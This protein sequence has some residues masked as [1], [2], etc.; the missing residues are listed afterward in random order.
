MNHIDLINGD[1]YDINSSLINSFTKENLGGYLKYIPLENRSVLA[2]NSSGDDI[3]NSI[4][5][6]AN[7]LTLCNLNIHAKYYLYLKIAAL[8]ALNY[9]EFKWF[10]FKYNMNMHNNNKMFSK[11]LFKK[12]SPILKTISFESFKF[13]DEL[14]EIYNA[15]DVRDNYFID[16]DYHNKAIKNFNIYLRNDNTFNKLKDMVNGISID[17]INQSIIDASLN[18]EYDTIL[19]SSLCTEMTLFKFINLI[20]KLDANVKSDGII[21]LGYLWNKN[22]YTKDYANVWKN[23]YNDPKSNK[24]LSKYI[25]TIYEVSGYINYLWENNQRD[26]KVLV[27]QKK[28]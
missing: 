27:Y 26:D 9:N 13:F 17:F 2:V 3:L 8:I 5:F 10:F 19:L 23:I 15:R 4:F 16:S 7:N 22:I 1:N 25:S 12:I 24:Y 20:K 21:V 18:K 11:K 14:L 28:N 6:G